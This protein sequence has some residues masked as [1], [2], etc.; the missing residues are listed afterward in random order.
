MR[1]SNSKKENDEPPDPAPVEGRPSWRVALIANVKGETERPA[2]SPPDFGAEFSREETL[3]AILKGTESGGHQP[4]FIPADNDLPFALKEI[5]PDICFNIAE[6]LRGDGRE[7]HVPSLL[8]MYGIPYTASRV[9]A[10]AISLDKTLTKRLW[11]GAGLAGVAFQGFPNPTEPVPRTLTV[12]TL[13]RQNVAA[14]PQRPQL[15][16]A[17]GFH[18]FPILEIESQQSFTPGVYGYSAKS[19]DLTEA[20]APRYLCPADLDPQLA[21][22]LHRLARRGHIALGAIGVSRVDFRLETAGTP[23]R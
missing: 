4:V 16:E 12:A 23:F 13:G 19:K 2:D 18:R 1:T 5:Q 11:R 14:S 8:E 22:K 3:Q 9:V 15:Y 10:N 20:G 7:A 17:D 21:E 6:G